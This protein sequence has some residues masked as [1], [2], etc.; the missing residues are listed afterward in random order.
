ML[1]GDNYTTYYLALDRRVDASTLHHLTLGW[2]V[3]SLSRSGIEVDWPDKL[4]VGI[5]FDRGLP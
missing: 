4:E 3:C 1:T 2:P 5:I